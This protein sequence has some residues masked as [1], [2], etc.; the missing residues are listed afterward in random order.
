MS[1]LNP[2]SGV[3]IVLSSYCDFFINGF[4]RNSDDQGKAGLNF[5]L[6]A[7]Q[8]Q[9]TF[10]SNLNENAIISKKTPN[11]F[12]GNSNDQGKVSLDCQFIASQDRMI[13]Q[14]NL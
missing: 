14:K 5:Q 8:D 13:F 4:Y 2:F 1:Y 3:E 12:C 11:G 10:K 7:I 6:R 9:M